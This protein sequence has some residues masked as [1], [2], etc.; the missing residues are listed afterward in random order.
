MIT[1]EKLRG[2]YE[3]FSTMDGWCLNFPDGKYKWFVSYTQ[4]EKYAKE[5]GIEI[6]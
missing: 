3:V 6:D 2:G 1:V 4:L 5:N